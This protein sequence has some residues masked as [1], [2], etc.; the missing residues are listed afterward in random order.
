MIDDFSRKVYN[1]YLRI[2]AKYHNRPYKKRKNFDNF[3]YN[4]DLTKIVE[5][6]NKYPHI[7]IDMFFSAPYEIWDTTEYY[8]LD[9]FSKRKALNAYIQYKKKLIALPPDSDYILKK[10]INGFYFIKE[11]CIKN[12]INI[13]SYINHK[14]GIY[15]FLLHL[16]EDRITIYNLFT[17]DGFKK[18][19]KENVDSELKSFLFSDLYINYDIMYRQYINSKKC[20]KISKKCLQKIKAFD[21]MKIS[22]KE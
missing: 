11:F 3:E 20:R 19:F 4:R 15:S 7:N 22:G 10:M 6:F 21:N 17:F 9:F 12:H 8:K 5:L 13:D 18:K 16:K 2:S 1:D 14:D